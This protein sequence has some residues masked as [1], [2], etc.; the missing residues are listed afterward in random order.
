M[1]VNPQIMAQ[2]LMQG[3][4]Q[5]PNQ[6]GGMGS[7]TSGAPNLLQQVLAMQQLKQRMGQQGQPPQPGQPPGMMAPQ[8][9]PGNA[10]GPGTNS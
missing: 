6:M 4:Q 9:M 3:G 10:M 5:P 1:S 2:L 8:A 7:A